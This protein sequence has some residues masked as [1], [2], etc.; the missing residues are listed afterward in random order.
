MKEKQ[1]TACFEFNDHSEHTLDFVVP[2]NEENKFYD[3][4]F[5]SLSDRNK[6]WLFIPEGQKR[7][8]KTLL[9][10][11]NITRIDIHDTSHLLEKEK[12]DVQKE[13]DG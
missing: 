7:L 5:D 3:W 11:R 2:E 13:L 6:D 9:N 1:F 8:C 12:Q 4:F 10:V